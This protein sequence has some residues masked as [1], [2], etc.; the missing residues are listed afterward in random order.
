[1]Q[2]QFHAITEAIC[3]FNLGTSPLCGLVSS[4]IGGRIQDNRAFPILTNPLKCWPIHANPGHSG[5]N[6]RLIR[7][8]LRS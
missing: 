5:A 2:R 4:L 3:P 7:D 6:P 8:Q 1:M